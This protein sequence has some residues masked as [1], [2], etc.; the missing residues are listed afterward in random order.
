[1]PAFPDPDHPNGPK[2]MA[3]KE[4][5]AK[6]SHGL[7]GVDLHMDAMMTTALWAMIAVILG[8]ILISRMV[9]FGN[10]RIRLMFMVNV[11]ERSQYWETDKTR[12][13]P[14][15]KKNLLYAPLKNK[16]HNR[17][18]ALS[19]ALNVGTLPSRLHTTILASYFICNATYCLYLD[20]HNKPQAAVLAELRGRTG[21]LAMVNMLPLFILAGRNNPLIP[22][23]RVSFDTYNLIHRWLGRL[24]I[25]EALVHT[26]C[27]A[28]NS[29][30][31]YGSK[32]TNESLESKAFLG[33]GM[34]GTAAMAVILLQSPSIVRHAFYE[35]F[36]HCHQL[37]ALAS[38]FGVW[39]HCD[40]GK[41]PSSVYVKVAFAC[42]LLERS[43]RLA[44][45]IYHNVSR[46]RG[47]TKITVE[48]LPGAG[49]GS[50]QA[51]RLSASCPRPWKFVPGTH[52]YIY[53]P[54][55]SF[56]QNHPFSI[57]WSSSRPTPYASLEK[58]TLSLPSPT[59]LGPVNELA[60][61]ADLHFV[62]AKR[63]GMT[64]SLYEK[65]AACPSGTMTVT[66][67]IEGPYGGNDNLSSYGT[68]VL[69]AGG[70]GITH[71]I[72]HVRHLLHGHERGTTATRKIVLVWSV[73]NTETLE[74]VRPFMDEILALPNRREVL[75]IILFVTRPRSRREVVSRSERVL[76][77]PGRCDPTSILEDEV[78]SRVGATA[79]TVCGPGA[80]G[81]EVRAGV[82]NVLARRE[83]GG[84]GATIDFVEEAFS[85]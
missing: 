79:V 14:W 22:F 27:W 39:V 85:W 59:S 5:M 42:W 30:N 78:A 41:L 80:F 19:T 16:R 45:L 64:A 63:T 3:G 73:K 76:M 25:L 11:P 10:E 40:T 71:Q 70:I 44:R 75:K 35:T 38:V 47:M 36:L 81:D 82:R 8:I 65:A 20:Y 67:F 83:D 32:V 66:G 7:T 62:I 56:I 31:A 50:L 68:C 72:G 55:L 1:M 33:Y 69:F 26:A 84:K 34:L 28:A 24:V 57:A 21:H 48:A 60:T 4:E 13:W 49:D 9:Q 58:E 61:Q 53:L 51:I 2:P 12:I 77:Y 54:S 43:V 29:T 23:L 74:W 15:L 6:Y 18:F 52:A 37:L 46:S 17:E